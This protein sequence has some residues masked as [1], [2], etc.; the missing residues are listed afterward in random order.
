[1]KDRAPPRTTRRSGVRLRSDVSQLIERSP[2][3][4]QPIMASWIQWMNDIFGPAMVAAAAED[5]RQGR[6]ASLVIGEARINATMRGGTRPSNVAVELPALTEAQ[7]SRLTEQMTSNSVAEANLLAGQM[8]MGMADIAKSAGA[9]LT[10]ASMERARIDCDPPRSEGESERAGVIVLLCVLERM[11]ADPRIV[12]AL[13][14][15]T[16]DRVLEQLR[17]ERVMQVQGA[18]AAHGDPFV[19]K[20]MIAAPPLEECLEDFWGSGSR[21][22]ELEQ[23]PPVHHAPHALLRR[24]GPSPLGGKFP[25]VGLLAS[26]YDVVSESARQ[27]RDRI[28]QGE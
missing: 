18:S 8:P 7:W 23:L 13:R 15:R 28:E 5:A 1:M 26:V 21:L 27:T 10:P 19:S 6:L 24:L 11:V 3:A 20:T 17:D 4:A 25:L 14:G 22:T 16:I 2:Q 12:F 9:S